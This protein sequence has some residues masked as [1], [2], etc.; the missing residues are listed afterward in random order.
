MFA[1]NKDGVFGPVCDTYWGDDEADVVCKQLGFDHGYAFDNNQY[2]ST[3]VNFAYFATACSGTEAHLQD[4][5]HL[6]SGECGP[7]DHAG[8]YCFS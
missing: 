3:D 6:T 2:G 8:L 5:F 1:V 4:C 7:N